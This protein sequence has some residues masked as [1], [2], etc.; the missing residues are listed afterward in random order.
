MKAQHIILSIITMLFS[1]CLDIETL[2]L[3]NEDGS[4]ERTVSLEGSLEDIEGTGFNRPREELDLWDVQWDSTSE[5]HSKF[6]A[7]RRFK[8]GDELNENLKLNADSLTTWANVEVLKRNGFFY[9]RYEYTERVWAI[10]PGP[11]LPM[12]HYVS[13]AELSLLLESDDEDREA[14]EDSLELADIEERMDQYLE[15]RIYE[16]YLGELRKAGEKL[17]RSE[18]LESVLLVASDSLLKNLSLTNYYIGNPTLKEILAQYMELDFVEDLLEAGDPGLQ[19]FYRRWQFFEE[20]LLNEITLQAT[21]PGVIR[22]TNATEVVGNRAALP[23]PGHILF[24]GGEALEVSS[25][26]LNVWAVVITGIVLLLTLI[27][28]LWSRSRR[29]ITP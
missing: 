29:G 2:T 21:L 24:F 28:S 14:Y 25:A 26:K 18:E 4:V 10:L 17:G 3:V 19:D 22:A 20:V 9:T 6:S 23:V 11:E 15:L 27:L 12:D 1:S 13:D 8:D 16:D 5:D 7:T